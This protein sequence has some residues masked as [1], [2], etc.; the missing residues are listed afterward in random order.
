MSYWV[1]SAGHA[2]S[3]GMKGRSV[4][5]RETRGWS[6][7]SCDT[8]WFERDWCGMSTRIWKGWVCQCFSGHLRSW[9]V[10]TKEYFLK[11]LD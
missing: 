9:Q 2:M 11:S 3:I 8:D 1:D 6:G 5:W 4:K 10:P 7:L